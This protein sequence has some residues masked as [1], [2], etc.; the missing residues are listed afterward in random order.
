MFNEYKVRIAESARAA[1]DYRQMQQARATWTS[2]DTDI[3][4]YLYWIKVYF[5]LNK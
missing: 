2:P 5:K 3:N 1:S 4:R